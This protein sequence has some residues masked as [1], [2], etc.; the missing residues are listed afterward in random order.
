MTCQTH[1]PR[2]YRPTVGRTWCRA[3][4]SRSAAQQYEDGWN[5]PHLYVPSASGSAAQQGACDRGMHETDKA[6]EAWLQ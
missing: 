4:F 6:M 5:N 1:R 2:V 3:F